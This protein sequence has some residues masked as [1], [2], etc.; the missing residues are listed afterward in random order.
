[1]TWLDRIF[2]PNAFAAANVEISQPKILGQRHHQ[3][4]Q[5]Q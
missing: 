1:M 4:L 5:K 3:D 2:S